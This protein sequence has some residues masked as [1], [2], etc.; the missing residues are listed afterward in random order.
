MSLIKKLDALRTENAELRAK[1]AAADVTP[2]VTDASG[3]VKLCA[4][5]CGQRVLS[6]RPEAIYAGPACRVRVHRR[7]HAPGAAS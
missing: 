4:C 2:G 6:A 1:L 5:G 3:G 7:K